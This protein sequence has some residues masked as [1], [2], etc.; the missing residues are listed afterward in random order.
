[1]IL[2]GN[3]W[4]EEARVGV[5]GITECLYPPSTSRESSSWLLAPILRQL[6]RD[7]VPFLVNQKWSF[8]GHYLLCQLG[9]IVKGKTK[10]SVT[11]R[12]IHDIDELSRYEKHKWLK[13]R[14]EHITCTQETCLNANLQGAREGLNGR[15]RLVLVRESGK[16]VW[17]WWQRGRP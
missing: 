6:I 14:D 17:M 12:Y 7:L 15:Q 11:W 8:V 10:G 1:M 9:G 2:Y 16:P 3:I 4:S 5:E 13:H